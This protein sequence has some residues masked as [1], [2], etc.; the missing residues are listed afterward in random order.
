MEA[1]MFTRMTF[2][3]L[4]LLVLLGQP[5][6]T[7]A[8]SP[9]RWNVLLIS[10]DDLNMH[11]GCYGNAEVKTPNIDRLAERSI[12]FDR[13]YCQYPLCNPS[14]CSFL[15]GRY[16]EAAQV[17]DNQSWIRHALPDAVTMPEHFRAN[18]YL[19]ARA[20]KI[21]HPGKD[22]PKSWDEGGEPYRRSEPRTAEQI[23]KRE[24]QYERWLAVEGDG[25]DQPDY[26]VASRAVELLEKYKDKPFFLAVGF[27]KPHAPFVAPRRYFDQYDPAKVRLPADFAAEPR[28]ASGVPAEAL[29]ANFDVFIR[30]KATEAEA[31]EMTVAY[32]AATSFMDAQVGRVLGQLGR[33]KLADRTVVVFFSDHGYHLGEKGM[34]S[35]LTLFETSA[36][37]PCLVAAPTLRGAGKSCPRTVELVDLYPTLAELCGLKTP[38]GLA[39]L[40]LVPL[41][42]DPAANRDKAAYTVLR[43]GDWNAAKP[44]DIM[45]RSIRTERYRYTEWDEGR[46]GT[47]LYDHDQDPHETRNLATNPKHA[48]A[49]AELKRLLRQRV[50]STGPEKR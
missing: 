20:G 24:K 15:S 22:D 31:R 32:H 17:L 18:G 47:E 27:G 19:T 2:G 42:H 28:L 8:D 36:R 38:E 10:V 30:R 23:A 34:W 6:P 7:W 48:A 35:K 37:V 5:N 45:G 9:P 44:D 50:K 29:R 14:R 13:A 3:W 25:P 33:L 26:L 1:N 43:R 12:R 40:S 16:P 4:A 39:G 49:S 21:F 46:K 11:V 41:L